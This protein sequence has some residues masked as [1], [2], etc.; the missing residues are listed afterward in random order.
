MGRITTSVTLLTYDKNSGTL[1]LYD[2]N[3]FR[4]T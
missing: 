1:K 3:N 4:K 2:V